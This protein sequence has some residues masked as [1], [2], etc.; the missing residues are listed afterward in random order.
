LFPIELTLTFI[1][2]IEHLNNSSSIFTQYLK[3]DASIHVNLIIL[4]SSSSNL[5]FDLWLPFNRG[6]LRTRII[7][8]PYDTPLFINL[9][10]RSPSTFSV[11][12]FGQLIDYTTNPI[13]IPLNKPSSTSLLSF[14]TFVQFRSISWSY[15]QPS[16]G[17]YSMI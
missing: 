14:N 5:H 11:F 10:Y 17:R 12:L 15:E 3:Y 13:S 7:E 8:F 4:N 16:S 9:V 2:S 1:L 6:L